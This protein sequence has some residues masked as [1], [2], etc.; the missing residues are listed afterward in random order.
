[1]HELSVCQALL[2]EVTGI[3][4]RHGARAVERISV[5]VGP[6]AGIEPGLLTSA[7][8]IARRG[9]CAAEAELSVAMLEIRVRCA[10]CG[11]V[12]AA[13]PNCL[14]CAACGGYRIRVQQGAELRLRKIELDVPQARA[15]PVA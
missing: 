10:D 5:E 13:Q 11:V 3:A 9:T 2:E 7:F 12:S 14:L 1:M 4:R 6:L 8:E 15:A